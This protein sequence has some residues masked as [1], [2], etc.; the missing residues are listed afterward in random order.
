MVAQTPF[1]QASI[2]DQSYR[3]LFQKPPLGDGLKVRTTA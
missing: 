2:G 3:Y 1:Y